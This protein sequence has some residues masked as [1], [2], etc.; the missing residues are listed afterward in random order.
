MTPPAA[1]KHGE[2]ITGSCRFAWMGSDNA[3]DDGV[4]LNLTFEV[5]ENV[6]VSMNCPIIVAFDE[7]SVFDENRN[8]VNISVVNG[9]IA[10]IGYI[11]G[12]VDSNGVIN[13][14][15]VLTLCQYYVDGC[16]CRLYFS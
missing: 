12:D 16:I 11:P 4:I 1:L 6:D 14:L 10:I 3:T 5:T 15:D 7:G 8:E 13:M 9:E 2:S